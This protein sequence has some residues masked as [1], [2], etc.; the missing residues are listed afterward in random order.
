MVNALDCKSGNGGSIPL[1]TF[2]KSSPE[3]SKSRVKPCLFSL[4][5]QTTLKKKMFNLARLNVMR[6]TRTA[7]TRI[8]SPMLYHL[9]YHDI[10]LF[11]KET[12]ISFLH[13]T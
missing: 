13:R 6:R 12:N 2:H 4:L 7:D 5:G 8:F 9:S 11:N 3:A 1:T 10:N